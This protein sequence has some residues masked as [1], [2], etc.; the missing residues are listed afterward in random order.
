MSATPAAAVPQPGWRRE[1]LDA[2]R[3][4]GGAWL[5]VF[6]VLLSVYLAGGIAMRLGFAAPSTAMITVIVVMNRQSG[7]V[8]AKAFYRALGTVVGS[9]AAVAMVGLFPQQ[10]VPFLV[11][12]ALWVGLCAGGA[13]MYRN[14]K[15][16]GFVLSGYTVGI[17][18]LPAINQPEQ[19]FE[20][21]TARVTE[22]LLG[23]LVSTVVFD[24][25]FPVR[26]R[27]TLRMQARET[28]SGFLD[29]VRDGTLGLLPRERMEQAHL[30]FVRQSMT[31]ED[32]RSSVVFE[33]PEF[34]ARSRR[35]RLLNQ[36]FMT[37]ST[38]FQALHHLI[39]RLLRSGRD[40]A[41]EALMRLY[42]PLGEAL[43]ARTGVGDDPGLAAR[44]DTLAAALP[45][46]AQALRATL[47]RERLDD[48]DTGVSLLRRFVADLGDT[49]H[50][51][52]ALRTPGAGGARLRAGERV[53]FSHATDPV[54]VAVTVARSFLVALGLGL[55]WLNSG[56]TTGAGALVQVV[57]FTGILAT[58]PNPAAVAAQITKGFGLG[59]AMAFACL[60]LVLPH[61]D[62]YVLFVAG[63]LPFLALAVWL[64]TRPP[65][66][67]M[68]LGMCLGF[69]VSLGIGQAPSF[70][71]ATFLNNA[72]AFAAGAVLALLVF[73]LIPSVAGTPG[74]RRRLL[75]E[76][77]RQVTLA[78]RAP[79]E[80][81]GPRFES[82]SRDL[83]LQIVGHTAPGSDESRTLLRWA[84][85]VH[86]TGLT[87]I[88]LRRDAAEAGLPP[89]IARDIERA[90][91]AVARLYD[92][93]APA[94]HAAALAHL[95][96][97]LA[98]TVVDGATP[99]GLQPVREHL[100]LLRCALRD[101][102]SVL[103]P[104]ADGPLPEPA[105][106]Q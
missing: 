83:F 66:F 91:D 42:R 67:G 48:F 53:R 84:L 21:A 93:R 31:L 28:L 35:M 19:L 94:D 78:A 105:H 77:R 81:L 59:L 34:R 36:R 76:L 82:V 100:H 6:K 20:L 12:F 10:P 85:S 70:D 71:V 45:G 22:V 32:L 39:N 49:L 1:A 58:M 96:A 5:F 2:L 68:S 106:A 69:L 47:P 27:Q 33:D 95:D 40:V 87:L 9:V 92:R 17:I 98:A 63:T 102:D 75:V 99:P 15:S 8:V 62:G 13:L 74:Q 14:F 4:E 60:T 50:T 43:A 61:M 37:C 104:Q 80:Q 25:V 11:A 88:E 44:L 24:V 79:L 54:A 101:G 16:Y 7:M 65:L 23:L 30:H 41:A 18:A 103:A 90:A 52:A 89:A 26:L 56:W 57:A 29:F 51:A 72:V 86:E 64:S 46:R 55:V 97:A 73:Q 38:R 3:A